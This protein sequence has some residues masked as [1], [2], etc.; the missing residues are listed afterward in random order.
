HRCFLSYLN[1][2]KKVRAETALPEQLGFSV[3][4]RDWASRRCRH[5]CAV[6]GVANRTNRLWCAFMAKT[7]LTRLAGLSAVSPRARLTL[8]SRALGVTRLMPRH[9]SRKFACLGELFTFRIGQ[10]LKLTCQ[11]EK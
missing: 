11:N 4:A 1:N 8:P 10:A 2:F 9:F 3:P 6:W 5:A 7:K